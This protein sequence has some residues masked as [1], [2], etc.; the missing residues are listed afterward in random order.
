MLFLFLLRFR[1]L[2]SR[3]I[4]SEDLSHYEI[5]F[6]ISAFER[7]KKILFVNLILM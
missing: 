2:I 6:M 5:K 7:E 4:L 1:W 3:Y